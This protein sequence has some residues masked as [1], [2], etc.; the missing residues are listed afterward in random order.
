MN[1]FIINKLAE[2]TLMVQDIANICEAHEV[3]DC[4]FKQEININE[5]QTKFAF[6]IW[7]EDKYLEV[8]I[9]SYGNDG[10]DYIAK[11]EQSPAF[12]NRNYDD[13]LKVI[14]TYRNEVI[15]TVL[16]RAML[17]ATEGDFNQ[18]FANEVLREWV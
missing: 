1:S 14:K 17:P 9:S 2:L 7:V 11:R 6:R 5:S 10:T 18:E 12:F 3:A 4:D 15:A 13:I 16:N 8:L